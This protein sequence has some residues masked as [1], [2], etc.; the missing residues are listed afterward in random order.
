MP[1]SIGIVIPT[2]GK[3]TILERT[4]NSL[5]S[6]KLPDSVSGIWVIENGMRYNA[7]SICEKLAPRLKTYYIHE[8]TAGLATARNRGIKEAD[9]DAIIFFDD[10]MKFSRNTIIAYD[11]ALQKNGLDFF[12]GGP[13]A[14]DYEHTPEKWIIKHLP[15]SAQGFTLGNTEIFIKKPRFLGGNHA[16][17]KKLLLK[18]GGYSGES[19]TGTKGGGVGE[20]TRLQESMI[21]DGHMG[22][23]VTDAMVFHYVPTDRCNEKW[24]IHRRYRHG[25]TEGIDN[26]ET[27]TKDTKLIL[28][29]PR[30]LLAKWVF[31]QIRAYYSTLITDLNTEDRFLI[32]SQAAELR[33]VIHGIL[34]KKP[35]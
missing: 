6:A 10:D 8:K 20:E 5:A 33:G 30:W 35:K 32:K 21:K 16:I 19:A 11:L 27:F 14:P 34:M 7:K 26:F 28:G 12:Y 31:T 13:L 9:V 25:Y 23:Y 4:L 17:P 2:F 3:D 18:Y 22:I 15:P 1:Y 29:I 24:L